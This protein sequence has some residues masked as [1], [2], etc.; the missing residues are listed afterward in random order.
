[1]YWLSQVQFPRFFLL[2]LSLIATVRAMQQTTLYYRMPMCGGMRGFCVLR[3]GKCV[4]RFDQSNSSRI[5]DAIRFATYI[6]ISRVNLLK[7]SAKKV[8]GKFQRWNGKFTCTALQYVCC[9]CDRCV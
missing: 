2:S 1:M 9:V 3:S 4:R 7:K 6:H 8:V 5:S